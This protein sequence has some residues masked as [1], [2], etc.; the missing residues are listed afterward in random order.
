VEWGR[1]MR[2]GQATSAGIGLSVGFADRRWLQTQYGITPQQ[3]AASGYPVYTPRAGLRDISV[4]VGART[5]WSPHWVVF[6]GANRS[7]LV[8]P[9]AA[10]PIVTQRNGWGLSAGAA[11]RF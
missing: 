1:D 2:L 6:Y 11:Y 3:S 10:S 8:G 4:G 9:A 7:R 5:E